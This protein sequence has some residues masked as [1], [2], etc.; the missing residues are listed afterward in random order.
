MKL[1][2]IPNYIPFKETYGIKDRVKTSQR[3]KSNFPDRI[4]VIVEPMTSTTITNKLYSFITRKSCPEIKLDK[5]KYLVP[6]D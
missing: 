5:H 1:P 2:N 4:P 3:I 6:L